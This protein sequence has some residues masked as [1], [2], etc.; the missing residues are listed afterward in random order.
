M[1]G[2]VGLL[3]SRQVATRIAAVRGLNAQAIVAAH[4]AL[5]TGRDFP[6]RCHLVGVGQRETSRAVIE[7]AIC[8]RGDR[9]A[10]G[11]RGSSGREVRCNM[12]W[13]VSAERL[14][15]V[16]RRLVASHAIRRR[17]VVIVVGVAL[18]TGRGRMRPSERKTG[19]AM[20]PGRCP[21]RRGVATRTLG[22][23]K[24]GRY[25]IGYSAAH[26]GGAVVLVRMAAVAISVC[27][28]EIVIVIGVATRA[29][30]GRMHPSQRPAGHRVV[31]GVVG[32]R[33]GVVT[34]GTICRCKSSTRG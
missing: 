26:R 33:D 5:R 15:T 23:R 16:P 12:V 10:G 14:R 29:W 2:V 17:Q 34:G 18:G 22:S 6:G 19:R 31:K 9:V 27:R 28:R 20:I 1:S 3:P 24:A 30:S 4:V 25:V 32:P 13:H 8:P 7:L 21:V 11:T